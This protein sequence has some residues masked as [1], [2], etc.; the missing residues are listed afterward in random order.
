MQMNLPS[1]EMQQQ[2]RE[3][4]ENEHRLLLKS[5]QSFSRC[6][7]DGNKVIEIEIEIER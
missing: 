2:K 5:Q 4:M 3:K 6:K 7:G 1:F